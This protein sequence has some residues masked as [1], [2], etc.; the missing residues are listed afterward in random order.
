MSSRA[1]DAAPAT[2]AATWTPRRFATPSCACP[3]AFDRQMY[4]P[5]VPVHLTPFLTGRG[6]PGRR[7]ARRSR[8]TGASTSR[9]GAGFLS[10]M[11]TVFDAPVM[12]TIGERH[13]W[14]ISP[15]GMALLNDPFVIDQARLWAERVLSEP[16][17]NAGEAHRLD[18]PWRTPDRRATPRSTWPPPSSG[19]RRHNVAARR[20]G[21][22][23]ACV[24]RLCPRAAQRQGV[25]LH[26]LVLRGIERSDRRRVTDD[27][28]M[29]IAG[30]H[31]ATDCDDEMLCQCADGFGTVALRV[32]A[33]ANGG[34]RCGPRRGL[35][36]T[37]GGE[38]LPHHP[39]TARNV[40]FLYMDGG[41]SQ[42]DTFDP[43]PRLTQ[44]HGQP[45]GDEDRADAVQQ[46]R[47]RAGAVP[48]SFAS[49][50]KAAFRSAICSRTSPDVRRRSG[51]HP[52]DGV[53][54]L[55]AHHR[56]LLPA[57]RPR[58]AGPAEHGRL[59]DLRPGQRVPG[60]ARLRRAATAA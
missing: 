30:V 59:G 38:T 40:I 57:H 43:K 28:S 48:G 22:G 15:A 54:L 33:G 23:R 34:L 12:T 41:P 25:H 47:Q 42:V 51:R 45:F 58:P 13:R 24:G 18:A 56:E 11:L 26:R 8:P 36:D 20:L 60:S 53:E 19:S 39:P 37:I 14:D 29:H 21:R 31:R 55:R 32:D 1:R 16:R 50:A 2:G 27:R 46:H 44:E 7:P 9:C 49:T 10:P 5:P 6:R 17:S 35:P 3:A 4:G 52:L